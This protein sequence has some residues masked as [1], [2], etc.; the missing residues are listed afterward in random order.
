VAAIAALVA[1]PVC[2]QN[3]CSDISLYLTIGTLT[4]VIWC[5]GSHALFRLSI[6]GLLLCAQE[7]H[8]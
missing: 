2:R 5:F 3:R 4:I 6:I 1:D 7:V 8:C